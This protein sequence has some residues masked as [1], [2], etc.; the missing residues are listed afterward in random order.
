MMK[1]GISVLGPQPARD[2][3]PPSAPVRA[4]SEKAAKQAVRAV[5][6]FKKTTGKK[7]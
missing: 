3:F 7:S 2:P 6:T 1:K 5:E 4:A